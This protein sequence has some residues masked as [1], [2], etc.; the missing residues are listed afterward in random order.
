MVVHSDSDLSFI[1]FLLL[2]LISLF[3]VNND[4]IITAEQILQSK[5][6]PGMDA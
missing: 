2:I 1:P 3:G 4:A 5:K 6:V